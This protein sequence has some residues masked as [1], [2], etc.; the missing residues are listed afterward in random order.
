[1]P[2][3]FEKT[4]IPAAPSIPGLSGVSLPAF[5]GFSFP[6]LPGL[7]GFEIPEFP[8]F[9]SGTGEDFRG[10]LDFLNGLSD[11]LI[12]LSNG[13]KTIS[14]STTSVMEFWESFKTPSWSICFQ[15][16][17]DSL[18]QAWEDL[19]NAIQAKISW[20]TVHPYL[21]GAGTYRPTQ[22]VYGMK[23]SRVMQIMAEKLADTFDLNPSELGEAENAT[24]LIGIGA[25]S[26]LQEYRD[27]LNV[28]NG[29]FTIPELKTLSITI[30]QTASEAPSPP[31]MEPLWDFRK[32]GELLRTYEKTMARVDSLQKCAD[33]SMLGF[34]E[35]TTFL[36][37]KLNH[38]LG[39]LEK[40][41]QGLQDLDDF[42]MNASTINS[43]YW[44]YSPNITLADLRDQLITTDSN[45]PDDYDFCFGILGLGTLQNVSPFSVLLGL[46]A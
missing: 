2:L 20:M 17:I 27:L 29:F 3:Q 21:E 41:K 11:A 15:S 40:V 16:V 12:G 39:M 19:Q 33:Q 46:E 28:V 10:M 22:G 18:D 6:G 34:S 43:F 30:E 8:G 35:A 42:F 23:P 7:P 1:M 31:P 44:N 36:G 25:V 14:E 9:Q 4:T 38:K 26:S 24:V 45:I 13:L 37:K 32:P 5:P